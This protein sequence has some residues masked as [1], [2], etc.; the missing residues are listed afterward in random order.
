MAN[1]WAL[2]CVAC[3]PPPRPGSPLRQEIQVQV[4][5]L[6][7]DPRKALEG[8][9]EVSPG[10][11]GGPCRML[12]SSGLCRGTLRPGPTGVSERPC[13]TH[14]SEVPPELAT[15]AGTVIHQV[16][17]V[18]RGGLL[19]GP[20]TRQHFWPPH[21]CTGHAP[22]PQNA[23]RQSCKCSLGSFHVSVRAVPYGPALSTSAPCVK[24][25]WGC[26]QIGNVAGVF[27]I[28]VQLCVVLCLLS[29]QW[30]LLA[31]MKV[32]SDLPSRKVLSQAVK[33]Q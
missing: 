11:K 27:K 12:F 7:G 20:A 9:G 26:V 22:M 15:E 25:I 29:L 23:L 19:P 17:L 28:L 8:S 3:R 10:G 18:F 1:A 30:G 6:G 14:L 13:R 33:M 21:L 24:V 2:L 16:P 31:A 32:H 5:N 4:V